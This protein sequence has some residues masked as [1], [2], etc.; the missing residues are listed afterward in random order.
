[1]VQRGDDWLYLLPLVAGVVNDEVQRRADD[2]R[3]GRNPVHCKDHVL[4][5]NWCEC[6]MLLMLLLTHPLLSPP[7]LPACLLP[8]PV[9][10]STMLQ[11]W[12][13]NPDM[14]NI[15][16]TTWTP[17]IFTHSGDA[18]AASGPWRCGG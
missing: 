11:V 12:Q 2:A 7:C 17:C 16:C 18:T 13:C 4:L 8:A 6:V 3:M 1:M 10:W 15:G 5:L 9:A 14:V